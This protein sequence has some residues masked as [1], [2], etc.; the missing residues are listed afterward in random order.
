MGLLDIGREVLVEFRG[1]V[2]DLKAKIKEVE[3]SERE[4]AAAQLEQAEARNEQMNSWI[5]QIG[6]VGLAIGAAFELG[7]L[8]WDGYKESIQEAKLEHAA[9]GI[10]IEALS[11]AAG[12]LKTKMELLEFAAKANSSQFK[13]TQEDMETAERAMRALE[14]RGV[15]TEQ[16][17]QAVTNAVVG[18]KTK[19]LQ[20]LGIEIDTH[21]VKLD[22]A[23][24]VLGDYGQKMHAHEEILKSLEVVSRG[25]SDSQDGIG[26][27]M[28]RT[29]VSL[30][31]SWA[32]LKKGL[33]E[34]VI[35][36]QPL[37]EV[38]TQVIKGWTEIAKLAGSAAGA[39]DF[40]DVNKQLHLQQG[41]WLQTYQGAIGQTTGMVNKIIR[42][43]KTAPAAPESMP[44]INMAG[45]EMNI[46]A[47]R[48]A[49]AA[50][51]KAEEAFYRHI[52]EF[53]KH[54]DAK[55]LTRAP[56]QQ[57]SMTAGGLAD[58]QLVTD[59][60]FDSIMGRTQTKET[61]AGYA[62]FL[63]NQDL[64][65]KS[66]LEKTFGKVS[67]FDIYKEAF[68][69]LEGAASSAM[70]AWIDGSESAG[71]AFKKF[72]G[73]S[74]ASLASQMIVESLKY[75]AMA[76]GY[77]AMYNFDGAAKAGE[78]S[79]AYA[80]GALIAGAAASEFGA[81]GG[82]K[83]GGAGKGGNAGFGGNVGGDHR[84]QGGGNGPVIVYGDSFA[85]DSPRM[86][87]IK[88]QQLV[89]TAIGTSAGKYS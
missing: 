4:L 72:I 27:S 16:A 89:S 53:W 58:S 14:A 63:H 17:Y 77:I 82:S 7:E 11:E 60:E 43:N 85:D 1:D 45:A 54:Y 24:N 10:N 26:D 52:D 47:D 23:G 55:L 31:E 12:G 33:G 83:S 6:K 59:S 29:Q 78:A 8:A 56:T 57:T 28:K 71:Q 5:E 76:L 61:E 20:A 49:A 19:G 51:A 88:A 15:P 32:E 25:V 73:E 35:A 44:E 39:I 74:L 68:K 41:D 22:E 64:Q 42:D 18:L 3:E 75:G 62:R 70:K 65:Q 21:K 40:N 84:T 9:M 86:R 30:A 79:A 69:G 80:A 50:A 48:K 46:A 36:F 81:G 13:N 38:L 67:D 37:I 34:L 2:T 87:Q 66:L